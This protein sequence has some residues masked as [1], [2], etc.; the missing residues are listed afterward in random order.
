MFVGV[1]T[2]Y[3]HMTDKT[4]DTGGA[5][6]LIGLVLLSLLELGYAIAERRS[7]AK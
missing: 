5:C 7:P 1:R 6:T 3:N 2:L 4:A